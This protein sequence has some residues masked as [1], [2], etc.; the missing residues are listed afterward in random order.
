MTHRL[1]RFALVAALAAALPIAFATP[2]R[3]VWFW[4]TKPLGM[5]TASTG[6]AD[7]NNAIQVNPAGIGQQDGRYS[8]DVN[9]ERREYEIRDY[10]QLHQDD[11]RFKE[12]QEDD[13][14]SEVFFQDE[15][16]TPVDE[17]NQSDFWHASIV[18]G[19]TVPG[20]AF[21][22]SF[23]A[24]N[25]PNRTFGEGEDFRGSVA[26]AGGEPSLLLIGGAAKYIQID[27]DT[28]N[29]N[30]DFGALL[31]LFDGYVGIGLVGRNVFG[32]PDE[33]RIAR[34]VA[35]GI[36]VKT[37]ED[38]LEVAFDS[39]KVFDVEEDNTFNFAAGLQGLI[40]KQYGS[41]GGLALR[42]GY[43]WDQIYERQNWSAGVAWVAPE[44]LLG[45]SFQGD[46]ERSRN[47]IHSFHITF[48]F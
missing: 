48:R 26:F 36:A 44:G 21:G 37:L 42:T 11:D 38:R 27:Q 6:L 19:A 3:A 1:A 2:A 40:Y 15:E 29:F 12:D 28:R 16:E 43:L 46:I 25:F 7:D 30:A 9:Y 4:G 14:G 33:Y 41:P 13:F 35:L 24:V 39:T 20:S 8:V 34:E 47:F 23:T 10:P 32:S 22:L 31:K 17:K 45:Y 18:D 5:G